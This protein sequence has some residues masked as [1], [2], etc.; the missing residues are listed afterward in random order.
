MKYPKLEQPKKSRTVYKKIE[1]F[2]S[3][4]NENGGASYQ[5][6]IHEELYSDE[7]LPEKYRLHEVGRRIQMDE[8]LFSESEASTVCKAVLIGL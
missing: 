5:Y 7:E 3:S 2:A 1:N 8:T 4:Q 6:E